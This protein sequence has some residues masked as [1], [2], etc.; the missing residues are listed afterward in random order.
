MKPFNSKEGIVSYLS[1]DINMSEK[2]TK[3]L[4]Y[5]ASHS[6]MENSRA[7]SGP[8]V[9]FMKWQ[10]QFPTAARSDKEALWSRSGKASNCSTSMSEDTPELLATS[11]KFHTIQ[12]GTS[13]GYFE[14][15][16][17][18]LWAVVPSL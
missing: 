8:H 12:R 16:Q 6:Q 10:L 3:L 18:Q 5:K 15:L 9:K 1:F 17:E 13:C 2:K 4:L 14:S 11:G 7:T